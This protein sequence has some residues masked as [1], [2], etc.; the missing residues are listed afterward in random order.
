MSQHGNYTK[1]L[2]KPKYM[3]QTLTVIAT[4]LLLPFVIVGFILAIPTRAFVEGFKVCNNMIDS[5]KI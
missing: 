3:K 5:G 1:D 2:T 4:I